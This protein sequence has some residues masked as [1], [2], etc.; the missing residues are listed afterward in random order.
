MVE[1][2][3]G[4]LLLLFAALL[5]I[6]VI[7]IF[8]AS[9]AAHSAATRSARA[10]ALGASTSQRD[11]VYQAQRANAIKIINWQ[12]ITCTPSGDLVTCT[13]KAQVPSILPG[14]GFLFGGNFAGVPIEERGQYPMIDQGG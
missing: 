14:G 10:Q 4:T 1:A 8:H 13:V 12:G 3:L 5:V 2:M 9:L 7:I 6:Q 11:S